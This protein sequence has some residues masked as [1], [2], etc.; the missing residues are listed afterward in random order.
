MKRLRPF[1]VPEEAPL[2]EQTK[3]Q[4]SDYS[5]NLF[6]KFFMKYAKKCKKKIEK[7]IEMVYINDNNQGRCH[8]KFFI[9]LIIREMRISG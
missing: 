3:L 4:L 1:A 7:M 2:A 9:A 6:V 8:G 5:V